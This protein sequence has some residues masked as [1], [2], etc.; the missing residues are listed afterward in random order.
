MTMETHGQAS[1]PEEY[2][3][4]CAFMQA[5][6]RIKA[7][8]SSLSVPADAR[9]EFYR[10]VEGAQAALATQVLG[11]RAAKVEKLARRC[12]DVRRRLVEAAGLS[13]F[14]LAPTLE[15]LLADP[16]AALA[17]PAFSLVLDGLQ[18]GRPAEDVEGQAA[19]TLPPFCDALARSAYE[20]WA[21]YGIVAALRPVRFWDVRSPDTVE[22]FAAE[23]DEVQVGSQ[24]TSPERRMPEAVFQ[25][26]DG[27]VFAMKSEAARELDYYGLRIV[28][29]R[30]NS[31]G[32]N[33][34]EPSWGIACF[35]STGWKAWATWGS[36]ATATSCCRLP[37]DLFCEVLAPRDLSTPAYVG[38]FVERINAVRSRRPVQVVTFDGEGDFPEGMLDD[39]T[40]APVVR[41]R[42]RARRRRAGG[43]RPRTG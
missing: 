24:I 23:T 4:L 3:A 30:D 25:T 38:T 42:G 14:N 18:N 34:A 19:L 1:W 37:S 31:A 40:V 13:A 41:A 27:R 6:G 43:H 16:L 7:T 32:G 29:R 39:P 10:L 35:C 12:A 26:A 9:P 21:Y 22:V 17:K 15:H 11:E 36:S 28:R 20:A 33:T 2:G 5:D 8:P